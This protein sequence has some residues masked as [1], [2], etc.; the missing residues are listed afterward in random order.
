MILAGKNEHGENVIVE[1]ND[2]VKVT[3][4]LQENGLI[5]VTIEYEDG[6]VEELFE[7]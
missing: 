1:E 4:T 2:G 6:T 5:R 3:K 7:K